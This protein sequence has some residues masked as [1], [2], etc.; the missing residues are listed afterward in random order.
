MPEETE[1]IKSW[2]QAG[3]H[4]LQSFVFTFFFLMF[5]Y[6]WGEGQREGETV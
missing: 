6:G 1:A 4:Q 3:E 2:L 5:I